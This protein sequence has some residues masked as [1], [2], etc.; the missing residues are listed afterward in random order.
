M[1][2][3]EKL[4]WLLAQ[5]RERGEA[6]PLE[7]LLRSWPAVLAHTDQ[8]GTVLDALEAVQEHCGEK[9]KAEERSVV[10]SLVK[11]LRGIIRQRLRG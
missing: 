11:E 7:I 5:W 3:A 10:V 4:D 9:L 2:L 8:F 1:T 6:Q